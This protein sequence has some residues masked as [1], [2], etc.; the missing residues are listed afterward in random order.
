[1]A[2]KQRDPKQWLAGASRDA[3][4]VERSPPSR[5]Q[6]AR[7][8]GPRC[9][10]PRRGGGGIPRASG[11]IDAG[12]HY[13]RA[14]SALLWH[15]SCNAAMHHI[16]P[17]GRAAQCSGTAHVGPTPQPP[18]L[19]CSPARQ[20]HDAGGRHGFEALAPIHH[21]RLPALRVYPHHS[22]DVADGDAG[23]KRMVNIKMPPDQFCVSSSGS[24]P[25][26]S[27]IK[28]MVFSMLNGAADVCGR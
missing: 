13:L 14:D 7:R 22:S 12:L 17:T 4:K 20:K 24:D 5:G 27:Y 11:K 8:Y 19:A 26:A 1:M 3:A 28:Y 25:L 6:R 2:P 23:D 16:Q 21:I 10:K 18:A 15:R 9:G